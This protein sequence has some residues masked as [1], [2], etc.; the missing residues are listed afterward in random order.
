MDLGAPNL[1]NINVMCLITKTRNKLTL[2]TV[3]GPKVFL[4]K[5]LYFK[6]QEKL[7]SRKSL[8]IETL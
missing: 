3:V 5:L 1:F 6:E 7:F 4:R 8:W 2:N